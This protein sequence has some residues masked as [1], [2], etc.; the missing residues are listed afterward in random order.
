MFN[1]TLFYIYV[2]QKSKVIP[3]TDI[4]SGSDREQLPGLE[5]FSEPPT[6]RNPDHYEPFYI[7][8]RKLKMDKL[9]VLERY[10]WFLLIRAVKLNTH[11]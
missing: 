5:Y 6:I 3:V 11:S 10:A 9:N 8:G 2:P 1:I 7:N 4:E